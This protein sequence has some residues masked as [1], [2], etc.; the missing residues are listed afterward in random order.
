MNKT[1]L[2]RGMAKLG[3]S[4]LALDLLFMNVLGVVYIT[5][6]NLSREF[7]TILLLGFVFTVIPLVYFY[8]K[9][10]S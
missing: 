4:F 10:I 2:F 1:K 3:L 8:G 7:A 5:E 9:E 6:N